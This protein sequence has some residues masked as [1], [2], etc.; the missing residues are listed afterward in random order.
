MQSPWLRP[1]SVW[2]AL[3]R[4]F[5]TASSMIPPRARGSR[6]KGP[7]P[8]EPLLPS[9]GWGSCQAEREA[10]VR[11]GPAARPG[12]V[13]GHPG[14]RRRAAVSHAG[15]V[16]RRPAHTGRHRCSSS[17]FGGTDLIPSC[18]PVRPP[19]S[20]TST[21]GLGR[22]RSVP[23]CLAQPPLKP[24]PTPASSGGPVRWQ[25]PVTGPA[26]V[27]INESLLSPGVRNVHLQRFLEPGCPG[28]RMAM[29]R[30]W[31][32][33]RTLG[34]PPVRR[35]WGWIVALKVDR[36]LW[37]LRRCDSVTWS[38]LAPGRCT[39]RRDGWQRAQT[40]GTAGCKQEPWGGRAGLALGRASQQWG[41]SW[42]GPRYLAAGPLTPWCPSPAPGRGWPKHLGG[43]GRWGRGWWERDKGTG[44]WSREIL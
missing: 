20:P 31:A 2:E 11:G 4:A 26:G 34:A 37:V 1:S 19:R 16:L 5:S 41:L 14:R 13:W 3:E 33:P 43:S 32:V 12:R 6:G 18:E 44:R 29:T 39:A 15:P 10:R 23:T 24:R 36:V 28:P 22:P 17:P 9:P 27:H 42:G 7:Q 8:G 25:A 35:R 21:S 40:S 30:A 38:E